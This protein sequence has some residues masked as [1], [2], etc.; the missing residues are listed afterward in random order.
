MPSNPVI[1]IPGFL[2]SNLENFYP[3]EPQN[4][5]GTWKLV[6]TSLTG[7]DLRTLALD[8]DGNTDAALDVVNRASSLLAG[9]YA[10]LVRA[11][12]AR[13]SA[14]VYVFPYDWRYSTA[15][16]AKLLAA[17]VARVRDKMAAAQTGWRG[18]VDFVVHSFGGLVFRAFLGSNPAPETIGQAVFIA[19][20]HM[21]LLDAAEAMIRGKST[22]LDGR[23]ELRKLARNLPSLYELLP[24]FNA[25]QDDNGA[26]LDLF[27]L[28]SWQENVTAVGSAGPEQSGFDVSQPRLDAARHQLSNLRPATDVILPRDILT[29]YGSDPGTTLV[30]VRVHRTATHHRWFDFD[31]A[32]R[33]DGDGVVAAASALLSGVASIR[34][35]LGDASIFGELTARLSFHGYIC[36]LD[37]TQSIVSRFL[38][39]QRGPS[40]LLPLSLPASRYTD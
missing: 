21:G 17:F 27:Q 23:K 36:A 29:I 4:S 13:R 31:N 25:V 37:E 5:W 39:G 38:E 18:K 40:A 32:Q 30:G 22:L 12:R 9:A 11:L 16:T 34:L 8:A 20:P 6:E 2:G 15:V 26:A 19:V 28:A 10:P 33:G 7:P 24:T 14:P 35:T 3:V 1:V